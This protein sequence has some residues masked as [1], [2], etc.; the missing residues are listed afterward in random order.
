MG[1]LAQVIENGAKRV[2][3]I[4]ANLKRFSH[5]GSA[6]FVVHDVRETIEIPLNLLANKLAR[7]IQVHR[8]YAEVSQVLCCPGE[9]TQVFMNILDNA[10]QAIRGSGDIFIRVHQ[11]GTQVVVSIR[12]TGPGIPPEIRNR[13]FDPFFTTKDIG[14]GTGLGMSIS[15]GIVKRHGG[16]IEVASEPGHGAEFRVTLPVDRGASAAESAVKEVP[17][18]PDRKEVR[19]HEE[20]LAVR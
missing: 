11:A 12:D 13:I 4:V 5:P 8:D 19:N 18:C 7:R 9:L 15:Y 10:Q 16:T 20:N 17:S 6:A 2:T 1:E 3:E 14:V